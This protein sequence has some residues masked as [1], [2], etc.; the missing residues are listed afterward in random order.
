MKTLY[1]SVL[2]YGLIKIPLQQKSWKPQLGKMKHYVSVIMLPCSGIL[3]CSQANSTT[4]YSLWILEYVIQITFFMNFH[5][6][7]GNFIGLQHKFQ[8][9]Q[10]KF[11]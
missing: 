2:K 6:E 11:A 5:P 3:K 9:T 8:A 1:K 7:V 10:Y 4:N